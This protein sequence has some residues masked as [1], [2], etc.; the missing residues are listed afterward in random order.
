MGVGR[1]LEFN[2]EEAL[3]AAM[4]LFWS[5]GYES[6]SLQNLLDA[7]DL[8]KSSFY[9]TFGSKHQLFERCLE[10]YRQLTVGWLNQAASQSGSPLAALEMLLNSFILESLSGPSHRGCMIMNT[11]S[12]FAQR[13]TIVAREVDDSLRAFSSVFEQILIK[14]R[15]A[16]EI[17]LS[18]DPTQLA[19]F[20]LS[21]AS[22]LNTMLKGGI[23]EETARSIVSNLMHGLRRALPD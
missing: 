9:Q 1:P 13:D 16:G 7:M 4:Q 21:N 18:K 2:P 5:K 12:E 14:A 3:E 11:A 17:P 22:G 6:T 15:D 10:R 23:D 19:Y 20:V 8:S